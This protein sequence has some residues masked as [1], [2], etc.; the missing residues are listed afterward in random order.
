MSAKTKVVKAFIK[1]C[2]VGEIQDVLEDLTNIIGQ[3]F[4]Q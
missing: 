3:E 4:L 2:P 1:H